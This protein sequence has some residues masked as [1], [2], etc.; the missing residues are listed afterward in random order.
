MK[1][2]YKEIIDALSY[3]CF[4]LLSATTFYGDVILP[5]K[6]KYKKPFTTNEGATKG[7]LIFKNLGIV[8]KIPFIGND[9]DEEFY[10]ADGE[11][12][13]DYCNAEMLKYQ[14][15][16]NERVS[17]FFAETELLTEIKD[18]PI[19]IQPIVEVLSE[20]GSSY[21]A[22]TNNSDKIQE[23]CEDEGYDCFNLEWLNQAFDYYGEN[24]FYKLMIFLND[25]AISDLHNANIGYLNGRPV[26]F[27]Y[28]SY[29]D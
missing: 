16:K 29:N 23:L 5:F 25:Y 13:W 15:A 22:K 26:I 18:Y 2:E 7:V 9:N 20:D 10:G 14:Y 3:C 6:E 4:D 27:D 12:G 21:N 8:I 24:K 17:E 1:E 19:Y 11:N 28:S